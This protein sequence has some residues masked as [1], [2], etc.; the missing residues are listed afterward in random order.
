MVIQVVTTYLN[1]FNKERSRHLLLITV[2]MCKLRNSSGHLFTFFVARLGY[3]GPHVGGAVCGLGPRPGTSRRSHVRAKTAAESRH[4]DRHQAP[5]R[6]T[7][8]ARAGKKKS[9]A[10]TGHVTSRGRGQC[11]TRV[12]CHACHAIVR[13]GN[14]AQSANKMHTLQIVAPSA[15]WFPVQRQTF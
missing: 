1:T 13:P 2:F 15:A 10:S 3:L 12:P 6:R 8:P 7:S 4:Q 14:I 5:S 9:L 11:D